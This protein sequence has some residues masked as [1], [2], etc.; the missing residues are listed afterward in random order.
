MLIVDVLCVRE[1]SSDTLE[2]NVPRE[3]EDLVVVTSPAVNTPRSPVC[4]ILKR[5]LSVYII[6]L[7]D[8]KFFRILISD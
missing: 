1:R 7:Y 8:G 6:Q 2:L 4:S 3:S 5:V